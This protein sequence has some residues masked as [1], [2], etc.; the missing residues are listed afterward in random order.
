M[1]SRTSFAVR[2]LGHN[3]MKHTIGLRAISNSFTLPE[4]HKIL[5]KTCREFAEKE[6]QPIAAKIDKEHLYPKE[7]V[8][9]LL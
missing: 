3:V 1:L 2:I 9:C 4:T 5:Q 6:L 7:Q 8:K